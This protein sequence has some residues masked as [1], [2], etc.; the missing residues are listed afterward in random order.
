MKRLKRQQKK[1]GC[2]ALI[3]N[4]GIMCKPEK[5]PM[6]FVQFIPSIGGMVSSGP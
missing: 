3:V 1:Q 5:S 4:F 6:T 2:N